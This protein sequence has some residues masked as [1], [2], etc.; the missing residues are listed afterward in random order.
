MSSSRRRRLFP[1]STGLSFLERGWPGVPE[2]GPF[3]SPEALD[4][5][6]TGGFAEEAVEARQRFTVTTWN[7][8]YAKRYRAIL[9]ALKR[10]RSEILLLQE[11]DRLTNRTRDRKTRAMRDV[12]VH[13]AEELRMHFAYGVEFR[14]LKQEAPGQAAFTGQQTLSVFPLS[15]QEIVRF[16]NQLADWSR[17]WLGFW[18]KREGGR[19]FLYCRA[20]VGPATVHLYNT[21]LESRASDRRKLAQL[22]EI[23][24]HV[25][26][27]VAPGAPVV[28]AGDLNTRES[29]RSPL[30]ERL[31]EAGFVDP[32][33]PPPSR[34]SHATNHNSDRRL[35]WVFSR[36]LHPVGA[37]IAPQFWGSN[38]RAVSVTYRAPD[39]NGGDRIAAGERDDP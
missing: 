16:E 22:D 24:A 12:P 10:L 2:A 1:A 4:F 26:E 21:H 9:A 29:E 34:R 17:G 28:L 14:E 11:L 33:H 23:L 3:S 19:M 36:N 39:T 38:H 6:M 8:N 27:N 30:V 13:L 31:L 15:H 32:L 25:E 7:T 20:R 18:Q 5:V 35:D 37:A